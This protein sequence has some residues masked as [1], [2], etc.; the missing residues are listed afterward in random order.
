MLVNNATTGHK[1]HGSGVNNIF[2]HNWSYMQ[3]WPYVMLS[4]VR[5]ESALYMRSKLKRDLTCYAVPKALKKMM[6]SFEEKAHSYWNGKY[7]VPVNHGHH[8]RDA[9][10]KMYP[11]TAWHPSYKDWREA[12]PLKVNTGNIVTVAY[13]Y[14]LAHPRGWK[15]TLYSDLHAMTFKDPDRFVWTVYTTNIII[16]FSTD[17][18][19]AALDA[20][21]FSHTS[22]RDSKGL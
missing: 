17:C 14:G 22:F 10:K 13:C 5:T 3:N 19:H 7:A 6:E 12:Y 15:P 20:I 11:E 2:I 16:K 21:D 1:L 8:P 9:G 4:R 18:C